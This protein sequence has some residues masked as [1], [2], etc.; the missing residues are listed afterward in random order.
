M[1]GGSF[2]YLCYAP[3]REGELLRR[4]DDIESM[5]DSLEEEGFL[6]AAQ[7]T[8][9]VAAEAK[10]LSQAI[11]DLERSLIFLKGLAAVWHAMEWYYSNDIGRDRLEETVAKY[12]KEKTPAEAAKSA[13][14]IQQNDRL[15]A[16]IRE[17]LEWAAICPW[18]HEVK[19]QHTDDCPAAAAVGEPE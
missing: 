10:R 4:T 15:K 9:A 11:W 12:L 3:D 18:C 16:L 6:E 14:L 1:S 19:G 13:D 17:A 8:R 5:A 2:F 7:D